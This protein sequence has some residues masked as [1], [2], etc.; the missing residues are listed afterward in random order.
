M[1]SAAFA[2]QIPIDCAQIVIDWRDR[3]NIDLTFRDHSI[4][5]QIKTVSVAS[6]DKESAAIA[7]QSRLHNDRGGLFIRTRDADSF[8]LLLNRVV[9]EGEINVES[10]APVDDDLSAVYGYLISSEGG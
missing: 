4:Q 10:V 5:K 8:Y 9:A 6:A 1:K 2:D 7:M 3:L